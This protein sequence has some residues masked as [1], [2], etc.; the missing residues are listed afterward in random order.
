MSYMNIRGVT[1][2][3]AMLT[4]HYKVSKSKQIHAEARQASQIDHALI[5]ISMWIFVQTIK[6]SYSVFTFVLTTN[7]GFVDLFFC[8]SNGSWGEEMIQASIE[9]WRGLLGWQLYEGFFPG[10]SYGLILLMSKWSKDVGILH[11]V[12]YLP[13]RQPV[14]SCHTEWW[15]ASFIAPRTWY[16]EKVISLRNSHVSD[17]HTQPNTLSTTPA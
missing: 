3:E 2:P 10:N 14:F 5:M 17:P 12:L 4:T 9:L 8:N 7:L 16:K 13:G 15:C 6:E 1:N 11:R